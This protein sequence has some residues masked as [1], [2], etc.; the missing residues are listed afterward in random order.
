MV[1]DSQASW[2]GWYWSSGAGLGTP[3]PYEFPFN[4]PWAGFGQ[5]CVNCHASADNP[6]TTYSTTRNVV[7]DPMTYLTVVPTMIPRNPEEPDIHTRIVHPMA[8]LMAPGGGLPQP[9]PSRAF[10]ALYNSIKE[11]DVPKPLAL[12]SESYDSVWQGPRP[13]GQKLFVTSD[14]CIGCHN[15]TQNNEAMP[16]M[17]YLPPGATANFNLSPYAEWRASMMGLS[18]RDPIFFAQ[19]ETERTLYPALADQIDNKCFSCHGAMGQ[20][21]YAAD[22]KEQGLFTQQML[23]AIPPDKNAVYGALARDSIDAWAGHWPRPLHLVVMAAVAAV[24]GTAAA[25]LFRWE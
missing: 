20:R 14:Q 21:Q 12:P 2:D 18:G 23:S 7:G 6:Y 15:A 22:T 13:A 25:R 11:S 10:M 19:V 8:L 3:S 24:F 1:R 4:Y 16:N 5:Y 17:L 9:P